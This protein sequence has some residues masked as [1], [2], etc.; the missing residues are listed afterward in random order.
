MQLF[1]FLP[2][3]NATWITV[4]QF[5]LTVATS[6]IFLFYEIRAISGN[7]TTATR[8]LTFTCIRYPSQL[9]FDTKSEST[10]DVRFQASTSEE[11]GI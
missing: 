3:R 7:V 1:V 4:P 6:F 10:G 11:G 8:V 9:P 2:R 5:C